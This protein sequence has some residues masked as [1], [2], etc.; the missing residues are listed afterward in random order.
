MIRSGALWSDGGLVAVGTEPV[1]FAPEQ[2]HE[3]RGNL[4]RVEA[5]GVNE[6]A[7]SSGEERATV[8]IIQSNK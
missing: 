3:G 4:G 7:R 1:V 6:K 8:T 5:E 2:V